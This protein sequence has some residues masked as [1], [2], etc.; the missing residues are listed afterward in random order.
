LWL[1]VRFTSAPDSVVEVLSPGA[2]NRRH[3]WPV[4]RQLYAKYG[5]AEYGVVDP[6]NR[7]AETFGRLSG[8]TL[9]SSANLM[10]S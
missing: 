9:G 1:E 10:K 6:E 2:E 5:V 7:A 8:Q 4:K 3:D